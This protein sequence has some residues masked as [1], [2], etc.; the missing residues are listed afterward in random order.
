MRALLEIWENED[1]ACIPRKKND[2]LRSFLPLK[3][4]KTLF[5]YSGIYREFEV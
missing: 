2:R 5:H 4:Q 1:P 3:P